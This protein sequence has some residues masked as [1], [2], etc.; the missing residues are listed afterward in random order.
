MVGSSLICNGDDDPQASLTING[1]TFTQP[2]FLVVKNGSNGTL[3]VNG[4]TLTSNHSAVQNWNKAQILGG[5]LKGQIW[6]DAWVEGAIGETI[7]GGDAQFTGEIVVDITGEVPPTL[8]IEGGSLNVTS[9]RVTSDAAAANATVA[10]S[11]GTFAAAV[12][13]DYCAEGYVPTANTDGTYGVKLVEGAYL[14]QDYRSGD[15]ASWTYPTQ[16][17]MAFAGWYKDAAF[18][19][20]CT[21][22]D[23]EGAAYAKFVPITD[24]LKFKGGSLRMDVAQP[25]ELTWLRFGY[26][27]ALPEGASFVENGWY[28]K[29]VSTSQP[30]DVRRLA[31]NNVLNIDG[32]IT[33]NLV[34]TGVT[35]NYYSANFSEKAFV[36]YVTADG[37][38][39]E[40]VESDYQVNSVLGVAEVIL[41]HPMASKAEKDYATQ[42]KA[43]V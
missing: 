42:I 28:F 24:L 18:T 1:G 15:Q 35:T 17:G 9:W 5:N 14:L 26:T 22:S 25:S 34:F 31:N 27:M 19:T 40:A 30:T 33:A 2:N 20:A 21:A 36:K 23:V 38:T 39:V 16:K 12:P 4:G 37:T 8:K 29:K 41:A 43:A 7:I 10:V 6:T 32:T 3:T 11:G 13:E